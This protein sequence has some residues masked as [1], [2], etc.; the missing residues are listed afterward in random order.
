M[1]RK[2]S[3]KTG[4]GENADSTQNA[5]RRLGF[6]ASEQSGDS[7]ETSQDSAGLLLEAGQVHMYHRGKEYGRL[8][9]LSE[10]PCWVGSL[11]ESGMDKP[12]SGQRPRLRLRG[13]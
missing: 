3:F 9:I 7:A 2:I 4:R 6:P 13:V 1:V 11:D 8:R 5:E 10:L 12:E